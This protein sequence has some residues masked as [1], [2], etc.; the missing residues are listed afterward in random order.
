MKKKVVLVS[1][2][3]LAVLGLGVY[4]QADFIQCTGGVCPGT[5]NSDV[6][7]GSNFPDTIDASGGADTA[8]GHDGMD[9]ING[10]MGNDNLFGGLQSDDID[11]GSENDIIHPGPDDLLFPQYANGGDGNDFVNTFA[12]ETSNC[13]FIDGESGNDAANLLGFGPITLT[14]PFGQPGFGTGYLMEEDPIAGGYVLIYVEESGNAGTEVVNGLTTGSPAILPTSDPL[15]TSCM[16]SPS[17][18]PG[19]TF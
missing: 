4:L 7:N 3:A 8:F 12:G 9:T 15:V 11:G 10:D 19:P 1:A 17:L 5:P 16:S 2:L 14:Q 18:T 13:L 6:I